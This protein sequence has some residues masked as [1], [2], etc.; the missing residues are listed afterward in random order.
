MRSLL[1]SF[2]TVAVTLAG[3]GA[4]P[5]PQPAAS[6]EPTPLKEIG[7]VRTSVCS[8]IVVHANSAIDDALADDSD[9]HALI[10]GLA[11]ANM[12][13]ATELKRHNTYHDLE[14]AAAKLRETALDGEAEVRRM[15]ALAADSPEPR[16]SDLKAFADAIGGALYRQ[17]MMAIDAQRL[18][19]VQQGRESRAEVATQTAADPPSLNNRAPNTNQAP[20]P[21]PLAAPAGSVDQ[22]F[23][24]VAAEFVERTKLITA[25]EGVAAGHSLGATTGC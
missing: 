2:C 15:R 7:R 22:A 19:A 16:K 12:D 25:D 11:G 6:E 23:R 5:Q 24:S 14:L 3:L 13:D 18:L 9:V 10:A 21:L 17:R 20:A 8:T 1:G 4:A